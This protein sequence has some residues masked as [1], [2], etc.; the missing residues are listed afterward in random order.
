MW[1]VAFITLA[2]SGLAGHALAASCEAEIAAMEQQYKLSSVLPK[3][4][5]PAGS[6]DTPATTESRGISPGD[7]LSR[8]GGVLAPPEGGRT[9]VIQPPSTG[10]GSTVTP[11]AVPPHTAQGPTPS[12]DT[13]ELSATKRTQVQTALNA[14]REAEGRG[15]E[16]ACFERLGEAR[17]A[18]R[19]N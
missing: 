6:P 17:A 19:P 1:K 9:A 13:A 7:N 12:S 15:D 10:P 18:A 14:A 4:E 3:A 2:A 11:P 16:K 8:S 5:A